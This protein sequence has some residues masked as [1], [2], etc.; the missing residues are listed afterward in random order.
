MNDEILRNIWE[1]LSSNGLTNSDFETWKANFTQDSTIQT[2]VYNYLKNNNLTQSSQQDWTTNIMGKTMGSQTTDAA[3]GPVGLPEVTVSASADGSLESQEKDTWI[4]R[5]LGKNVA[6]DWLGDIWRA[7]GQ[8]WAQGATVDEA[9]DIYKKGK[10]IS[11]AD[12]ERFIEINKRLE[13]RG[14]SDEMKE[15]ERIKNEAGGGVWGFMKGM[16]MT[17]GQV[18]PQVIVS[19]AASMA[20][21]FFDS[22]EAIG[23]TAATAVSGALLG[24][25]VGPIGTATGAIGG[26]ISGLVGSMETGLTLAELLQEKLEGKEFNKENVRAILE[27][28]EQFNDLKRKALARG[29]TIGAVEGLTAGLSRGVASKMWEA[30]KGAQKI[31]RKTAGIEMLGGAGGE[32]LGQLAADQ[33]FDIAEVLMEGVAEVKGVVNVSDILTKKEYKINKGK[34]KRQDILDIINDDTI[35]AEDLA[36]NMTFD[37]KGD[38]NLKAL[39]DQ[40]QRK[41]V[42]ETQVNAVIGDTKDRKQLVDLEMELLKLEG[43]KSETAKIQKEEVKRKIKEITDQYKVGGKKFGDIKPS[44][45]KAREKIAEKAYDKVFTAGLE[46][47]KKHSKLYGLKF[48]DKLS[49]EQIKKRFGKDAATSAGF[50]HG[51]TIFVNKEVAKNEQ[52]VNVGNHELLHGI[53]RKALKEG[54]INKNI[55]SDLE[56]KLGID[57]WSKVTKRIKEGGYNTLKDF[58]TKEQAG[59]YGL[60]IDKLKFK[61]VKG[62][63]TEVAE[64]SYM[65]ANPDEYLTLLSDAIRN[66]EIAFD[67]TKFTG[68]G[69][70]IKPILRA[71]GFDKI[72]FDSAEGVYD[73]LKEYNKSIHKGVLSSAIV[74]ET[75]GKVDMEGIKMSRSASDKVQEIYKEKGIGGAMDI[76]E[77]FKPITSRIAE[78]RREAPN[79]DK[80]LLMS[81]IEIGERGIL[82]LIRKYD[83]AKGVPL[84]AYINDNLPK[85]AIEASRRVLGE[86][87]TEDVSERIDIAA[88]EVAD[89]ETTTKPEKKKIVLADR[90]GVSNEVAKTIKDIIPAL[91]I[92]KLTFKNL[93]NKIPEITGK[94]FGISPKKIE[95]GANITKGE[96]QSAQMFIN[97]N[98]DSLIAMLPEGATVSGTAT[99]V[100]KV[101]LNEFYTKGDRA[102][103][104]KTGTKAGLAIQTKKPNISRKEFLEVFGII[105]GKPIRT[106]RNTSARVLALANQAG[107]MMT[108]QAV[109]QELAKKPGTKKDITRIAEGKSKTLFSRGANINKNRN[110]KKLVSEENLAPKEMRTI[111]TE[112][113]DKEKVSIITMRAMQSYQDSENKVTW[114]KFYTNQLLDFFESYPEHYNIMMEGLTGSI[115]R[116]AFFNTKYFQRTIPRSKKVKGTKQNKVKKLPFHSNS[117]WRG[118][119]NLDL[120]IDKGKIDFLI[121]FF[122]DIRKY[123]KQKGNK[124]IFQ[125]LLTHFGI[126]QNNFMRKSAVLIMHPINPKTGKEITNKKGVEEHAPQMEMARIMMGAAFDGDIKDAVKL[127]KAVYSQASLLK[128]DDPGGKLKS[129]MGDNF[130]NKVV[131]RILDNKLDFLPNGYASIYRLMEAGV[132]PFAYKLI[133]EKQ[134]IAEYFGVN[135]LNVKEARQAII[136]VFEGKQDIKVLREKSKVKYSRNISDNKTLNKANKYSRSSKNKSKGITIL[137]FDDTLATTKSLVKYTTPDGKTGT[138][139]AEEYASTY[140]DL[141]DQGYTFDFSDFNKV[142]K[143]KLAPLFNKAMKLQSKFGPENMF[144]LTARPSAAQKAIFDFLKANGLNIPLKNITGLGNSTAE[145]KALWV[146]D[147]VGEGFNDFYFADDALQNVQAVKNMLDQ[148]DVKSKVQQAKVKFSRSMNKDFNNI[149]EDVTGIESKK[150]FSA[151]KARKRGSSKG[152]FRFFIPPSHEDFVGLLYNFIGKG[153]KGNA[154]RDFFEKALIRPLNR[155]Y[156]ELNAAKQSIANDYKSLN[157]QF[158]DVKKKLTKKTPDGDFTYQDAIRTYLWDKHGHKVPGLS[159]T[160]QKNL[161]DLVKSDPKLQAY[162]ETLNTISKQDKYVAPTESWE[163]GDIRTDLDDATGR[164]GRKEFF[165]EFFENADIIFSEENFNKIEAAYGADVV[166]ALKDILYRVKTG[167]NRPSGQNALVNKFLNYLNGSVASTM[168]FNIRSAVLQQMSMVNFINFADNNIFKAASAFANQKQYWADWANIFNSDFM[169]QRR[170]GIKTDVNGAELAASVKNAKNPIQAAIKKLL[171]LGFLPTQIGDN[172]AIATGGA[173]FLRNRINTYLKQGLSQKEAEAKAWTDFEILAEATQQSARPDMVSQQQASPLG[174]VILAFQNVTSQFNRLGKKAFLD[175]KNRRISPEYRNTKNPQLQ[176]DIG[177]ISR[178]AYYLGIQNLIFYSLQSALFM[179]MFDDDEED[180]RWLK[181]KERVVNGSIDSVLRGTGVWGAAIAT[182][183]NMAIKWHEQREKGYNAD[184]SAV[185]MEM[186]NVSPPLGIKARKLVNAEKTLNY[187]K[188]VIDEMETFDIDN[189]MWSAYTNYI[190]ATTNVP[191]NRLYNKT[192]NV[193]NSLNSQYTALERALMFSGWSQWNLGIPN[194]KI[195]KIKGKQGFGTKKQN[196]K[197]QR[198]IIR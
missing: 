197:Q 143:G 137:D 21:T 147:K 76:I 78:K 155:A 104:A 100:P 92:E 119:K 79:Y 126:D 116:A 168:F 117:T 130:F 150:R 61:K 163:A 67:K 37:I 29:A 134:T 15:Y 38:K 87:F 25:A 7:G 128:V 154:H 124:E 159:E 127:L 146:A 35:T 169:K 157:K 185:L 174:K 70:I 8:G 90:L 195:E 176:S 94:L 153:K 6:T 23:T 24:T 75:G 86:E 139:N 62:Y 142:V 106:D 39:I 93:K 83:P 82:D 91:D 110:S 12:L 167:Q 187:N 77:Q 17:R 158:A 40:K 4:E 183:K 178:I 68:L 54:K 44:E 45:V 52:N 43:N 102:K 9:F 118:I 60:N 48:N 125:E 3:V 156:R 74:K 85:R 123:T 141:L 120:S 50:I 64:V 36:N 135:N 30:G 164:I 177:N 69:R 72:D 55:I 107:K 111:I 172:I 97:K 196:K 165:K 73:F 145:A 16:A 101:L 81:E 95:T 170:K 28:E 114:E 133:N 198:L 171:E 129:S 46:F 140:E 175:L 109:R 112:E 59:L 19:S 10:N 131:P 115:K 190:E 99:G 122:D 57:N 186:L 173:T 182:L 160:D 1:N 49:V 188:K 63:D 144:V 136:D 80:E 193:R 108:N 194:E 56:S 88:E 138:L 149:L 2:N 42:L 13:E 34:A 103:M 65:E 26:A 47:A 53:L 14:M 179:A 31:A 162:A 22:E 33:D 27:N 71:F 181:K 161:V 152:K 96:L 58:V 148:F 180:E 32:A 166:S 89:V 132:D 20:S 41:A 5:S 105:D 189:P 113:G 11:D 98:A 18:I 191:L 51:D 151:I 121:K 184:E 84:A 192:Q 66:N